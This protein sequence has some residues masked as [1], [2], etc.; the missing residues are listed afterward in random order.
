MASTACPERRASVVPQGRRYALTNSRA[1]LT[2]SSVVKF[3]PL[4]AMELP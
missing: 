1:V 2:L 3:L 4:A